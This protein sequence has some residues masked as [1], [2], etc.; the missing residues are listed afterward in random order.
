MLNMIQDIAK[1]IFNPIL[2]IVIILI[3]LLKYWSN[4]LNAIDSNY[5]KFVYIGGILITGFSFLGF[6]NLIPNLT[7]NIREQN[8]INFEKKFINSNNTLN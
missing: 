3:F 2:I 1:F 5:Q 4:N 6:G 7:Q 8:K